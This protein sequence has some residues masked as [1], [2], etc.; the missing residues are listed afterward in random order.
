M[1][2][3]STSFCRYIGNAIKKYGEEAFG[4]KILVR[5]DTP[6]EL[7]HREAY[8]I[9]IFNTLAPNGYNLRAGGKISEAMR[10][11]MIKGWARRKARPKYKR[12]KEQRARMSK[13][14]KGK[15]LSEE[16][17]KKMSESRK[18]F[19]DKNRRTL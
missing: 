6:E 12:S 16:T 17:K 10:D 7:D 15:I 14:Q 8:Y 4:V 19:I 3:R 1:H 2:C 5:C 18:R 11:Q 13:A 9:K